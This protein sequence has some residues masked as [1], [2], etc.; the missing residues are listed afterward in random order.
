MPTHFLKPILL[1]L[2]LTL[3]ILALYRLRMGRRQKIKGKTNALKKEL[4][5]ILFIIYVSTVL[6]VTVFPAYFSGLNNVRGSA[7]MNFIPVV[8]NYQYFITTLA[9]PDGISTGFAIE[10]IVGNIILFIPMGIFLPCIFAPFNSIKKIT[11]ICFLSSL[12]I[13]L[14]QLILRQF[15]NYRT[16]DV[17]DIILNTLGGILGWVIFTKLIT[18]YLVSAK[19][20]ENLFK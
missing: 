8:N 17:D 10:N 3:P 9:E 14:T 6:V 20:S 15:G 13:E 4:V 11:A 16:A 7:T 19:N 1:M 5:F 18:R 12:A 2:G